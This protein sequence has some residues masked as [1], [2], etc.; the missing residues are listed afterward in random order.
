MKKLLLTFVALLLSFG[1][2]AQN[3]KKDKEDKKEKEEKKDKVE[4]VDVEMEGDMHDPENEP[5]LLFIESEYDFGDIQQGEV[6]EHVFLF[7]NTGKK[8]LFISN[9]I[10]T[11]D[12]IVAEVPEKPVTKG[13][14]ASIRVTFDSSGKIGPQNKMIIIESNAINMEERIILKGNVLANQM[15]P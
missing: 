4:E 1:A 6:F 3:A 15:E 7:E 11:C 12:C 9:V 13:K 2:I 10:T 5:M 8:P 14:T